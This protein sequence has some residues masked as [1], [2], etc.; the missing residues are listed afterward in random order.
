MNIQALLIGSPAPS[1]AKSGQTGYFKAP[2]PEATFTRDGLAGDFIGDTENHGGVD[3]AV[4]L[5][6]EPDRAWWQAHLDRK[7]PPGFFGENLLLSE[8]H[9]ADI[10]IGD[11][12]NFAGVVLEITA[13]RIPCA[14]YAAHLGTG[15][16]IKDFYRAGRPGAYARVVAEGHATVGAHVTYQPFTGDRITMAEATT[17]YLDNFRDRTYLHRALKVPSHAKLIKLAHERLAQN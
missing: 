16:A 2:V 12:M 5:F 7:V 9:S 10:C 6:T 13:P 3:Q 17:A 14:T 8:L 4:Y 15:Q 11:R 1:P